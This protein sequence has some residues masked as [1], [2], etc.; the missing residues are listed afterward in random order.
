MGYFFSKAKISTLGYLYTQA[1][2]SRKFL[3]TMQKVFCLAALNKSLRTLKNKFLIIFREVEGV[4]TT[5]LETK[6]YNFL[7]YKKL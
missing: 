6:P 5:T 3:S 4:G 1:E 2:A 7:P